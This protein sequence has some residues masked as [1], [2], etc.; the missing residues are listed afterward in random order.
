MAIRREVLERIGPFDD[1]LDVGTPTRSGGDTE[2]FSRILASGYRIIYD[3]A[4][5][6]WH[7]HR[8]SWEEL[9]QTI[10]GYGVG[11]YAFWTR[12]V[13]TEG[14]L[15]NVLGHSCN[16]FFFYQLRN[17][18]K[19]LLRRPGSIPLDLLF[20]ELKGC[21][22]GPWAYLSSRKHLRSRK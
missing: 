12:I 20:A 10:Y 3:P 7:R 6:S 1:A 4:A 18:F 21:A 15:I 9:R 13:L 8:R 19:S 5:L 11:V 17:V 16:W 14:N 22:A 2:M